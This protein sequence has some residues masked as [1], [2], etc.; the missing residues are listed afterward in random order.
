MIDID[1]TSLHTSIFPLRDH[2]PRV[3]NSPSS[4]IVPPLAYAVSAAEI[5][6]LD[7]LAINPGRLGSAL[8]FF[9]AIYVRNLTSLRAMCLQCMQRLY[10][11][12]DVCTFVF[13]FSILA[14]Q[15]NSIDHGSV[16]LN[17]HLK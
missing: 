10:C 12:L 17:R 9:W 13:G 5:P 8:V 15:V 14:Q 7:C 6:P 4:F 3:P 11:H 2:A 16:A 1:W